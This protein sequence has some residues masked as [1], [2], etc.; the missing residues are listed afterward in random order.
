MKAAAL[1]PLV[2]LAAC[3]SVP[4]DAAPAAPASGAGWT[5]EILS[6]N[7]YLPGLLVRRLPVGRR[8]HP[9]ADLDGDPRDGARRRRRTTGATTRTVSA[10]PS[11]QHPT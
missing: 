1:V 8:A 9:D 3:S 10:E 7:V 2:A 5:P 11:R 4:T 6:G